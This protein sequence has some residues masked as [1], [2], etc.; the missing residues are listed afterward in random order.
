MI[1]FLVFLLLLSLT[2]NCVLIWYCRKLVQNLWNGVNN[3]DELQRLLNEYADSLKSMYS[4]EEF[5]GD[6]TIKTA[7]DNTKI[8]SEAC[9]VYKKTIIQT[10]DTEQSEENIQEETTATTT[11]R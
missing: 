2:A 10:Q 11:A 9:R 5:Y 4:L 3:V 6:E 7:I 1:I 8:I